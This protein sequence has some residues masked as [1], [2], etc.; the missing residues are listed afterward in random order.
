MNL[1]SNE[2][3]EVKLLKN[4]NSQANMDLISMENKNGYDQEEDLF[5]SKKWVLS[6]GNL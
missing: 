3:S 5:G 1:E 4:E 2:T 6:W